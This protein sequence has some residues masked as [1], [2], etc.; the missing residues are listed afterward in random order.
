M[1]KLIFFVLTIILSGCGQWQDIEGRKLDA[2]WQLLSFWA[3]WCEY[4]VGEFDELSAIS[5][6]MQVA[7][8]S[9]QQLSNDELTAVRDARA[10]RF[11]FVQE[12]P[13]SFSGKFDGVPAH[14]LKSPD[15][16]W[17]GPKLGMI[18]NEHIEQWKEQVS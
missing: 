1:K 10:A 15:G 9:I 6:N 13:K 7:L 17:H 12:L 14:F 18:D 5:D 11:H 2:D 4:C 8:Y 3:P 16:K